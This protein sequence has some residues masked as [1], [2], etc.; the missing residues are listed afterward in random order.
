[1]F[2]FGKKID[3]DSITAEMKDEK[4]YLVDVRDDDEWNSLHAKDALHLSIDLIMNG[5][6]PT[7]DK[8]KKLYLYCASGGRAS[9]AASK[10]KSRGYTVENLGGLKAWISAGGVTESGV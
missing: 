6:V 5:E 7:K 8:S 2:G 9:M 1:M 3:V 4:A 10:L